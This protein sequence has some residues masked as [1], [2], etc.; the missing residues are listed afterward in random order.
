MDFALILRAGRLLV[1]P[2]GTLPTRAEAEAHIV[3]IESKT[4]VGGIIATSSTG[5]PPDD[6]QWSV[7]AEVQATLGEVE[8][9]AIGDLLLVS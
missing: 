3:F 2:D 8:S 7:P 9:I 6:W 4:G 1:K 5:E